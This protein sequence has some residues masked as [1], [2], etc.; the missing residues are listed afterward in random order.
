MAK[1]VLLSDVYFKTNEELDQKI[2]NLLDCDEPSIG[3]IPSCSDPD[4]K[5]F[6]HTVRYYNQLGIESIHYYDLDLEYDQSTF[7]RIFEADAIHLSGGNTFYFLSLLQKRNVLG[8]L[9]SYVKR[10]G[11]L[12]GVSAGSILTTPTIEIAEYGQDADENHVDLHD[13]KALGLVDFEFAPHWDG[14]EASLDSLRDYADANAAKVYA[15]QDGD[16]IVIDGEEV[17]LYGDVRLLNHRE[18]GSNYE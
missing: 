18:G 7:E 12:I 14:E 2:L 8:L 4:R 15:C 1:L 10:G 16:G 11:I 9:R 6:E 17:E 5:Y 13:K 3:Y